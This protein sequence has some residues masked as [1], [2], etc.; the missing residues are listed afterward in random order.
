MRRI[1]CHMTAFVL[2][3]TLAACSAPGT[4]ETPA[5][6]TTAAMQATV[7]ET[8]A[9]LTADE[10]RTQIG[11]YESE[12]NYQSVYETALKLI[13]LDP[14]DTKAYIVAAWALSEMAKANYA[15]ID[16]LFALGFEHADDTQA[17][18]DWAKQNQ[19]DVSI[20]IPFIPDY[21]SANKLILRALQPAT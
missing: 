19:P 8:T 13:A 2:I 11:Q 21:T 12:G 16:R 15:E 9:S 5:S 7:P 3:S 6:I 4:G 14:A 18:T 10:L 1:I 17:I 20:A